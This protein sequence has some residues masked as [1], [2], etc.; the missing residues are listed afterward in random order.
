MDRFFTKLQDQHFLNNPG[1]KNP[2]IVLPPTGTLEPVHVQELN[3]L[4]RVLQKKIE[5]RR[6][7]LSQL[8][9]NFH[10]RIFL[11]SRISSRF[12]RFQA[13]QT[14]DQQEVVRK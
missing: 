11:D 2:P 14:H 1:S 7:L 13:T 8:F 4:L 6:H 9:L 5:E 3:K 12:R 10:G